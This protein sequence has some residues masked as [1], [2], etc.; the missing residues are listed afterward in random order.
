[1]SLYLFIYIYRYQQLRV[2]STRP[3]LSRAFRANIGGFESTEE[4][5][6]LSDA[7]RRLA[8]IY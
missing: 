3:L 2:E 6:T 8:F 4:S 7:P 5:I 1:M